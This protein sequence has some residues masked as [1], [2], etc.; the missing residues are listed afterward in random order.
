MTCSTI[1]NS[2]RAEKTS[3]KKFT[4]LAY[5]KSLLKLAHRLCKRYKTGSYLGQAESLE[6][7]KTALDLM[8]YCSSSSKMRMTRVNIMER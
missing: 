5:L 2:C 4:L 8:Q 6:L 3:R 7:I 1:E